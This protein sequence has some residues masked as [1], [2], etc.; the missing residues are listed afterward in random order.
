[1]VEVGRVDWG[2]EEL[3]EDGMR[4]RVVGKCVGMQREDIVG[5]ASGGED[6]CSG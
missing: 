3:D 5:I 4:G 2:G 1:L 6:N